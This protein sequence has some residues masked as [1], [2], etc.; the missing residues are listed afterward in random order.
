MT[1]LKGKY[2][3]GDQSYAIRLKSPQTIVNLEWLWLFEDGFSWY[4]DVEGGDGGGGKL[5]PCINW[6]EVGGE[7]SKRGTRCMIWWNSHGSKKDNECLNP[8]I[9]DQRSGNQLVQPPVYTKRIVTNAIYKFRIQMKGGPNGFVKH[10]I[11]Y[12]GDKTE[13][14]LSD[15]QG[16]NLMATAQ[17]DVLMDFAFFSGGAS[18][19]YSPEHDSYARHGGV[20]YWTGEAYWDTGNGDGGTGE[21]GGGTTPTPPSGATSHFSLGVGETKIFHATFLDTSVSP[22][23]EKAPGA[24]VKWSLTPN[25][26]KWGAQAGPNWS[27]IEVTGKTVGGPCKLIATDPSSGIS[28]IPVDVDITE[29]PTPEGIVGHCTV[30]VK[31]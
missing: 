7:E 15:E 4:T 26:V 21:G 6:G 28:T 18:T 10:W 22:P 2:G 23:K 20:R 27:A 29:E 24:A 11:T 16:K 12:P 1:Y 14:L 25:N 3:M 30:E 17:D 31:Q 8:V 5:G 13:T 9:Q 19:A